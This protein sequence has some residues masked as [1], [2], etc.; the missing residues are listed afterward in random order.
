MWGALASMPAEAVVTVFGPKTYVR[1]SGAP[2]T[3]TEEFAACRPTRSFTLRVENGPEGVTRVSSAS[4][5]LN[6]REV[7]T[8]SELSQQVALIERPVSLLETNTLVVSLSGTPVGT[9]VVSIVSDASCGLEVAVSDPAGGVEVAAGPLLVRGMVRGA[10]EIGVTVNGIA[11]AV[12]G[13][14]FTALV[15]VVPRDTELVAVAVSPGGATVQARQPLI[16]RAAAEPWARLRVAPGM[17]VAPLAVSFSVSGLG[18]IARVRLDV[19]GDGTIDF[20][21]PELAE[22]AFTY[23]APGLYVPR[24][25]VTDTAGV[26]HAAVGLVHVYDPGALD[27]LMQT[28]W[29]ALRDAAAR[30]DVAA[31]VAVFTGSVQDVYERQLR[32]L[33]DAGLLGAVAA[34]LGPITLVDVK[35]GAVEYDLRVVRDGAQL[36]FFILFVRDTDGIWRLRAL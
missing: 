3:A 20:E 18:G 17:G 32:T 1:G 31:A 34:E 8:Q 33:A 23:G 11:A 30:G 25:V 26:T 24:V 15:P 13:E 21:G 16:V 28:K 12:H 35:D 19:D 10:S 6:G 5:V 29:A 4:L 36:S 14:T 2:S 7:V 22:Q 27:A 9:L